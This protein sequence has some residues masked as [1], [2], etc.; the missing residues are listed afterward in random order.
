MKKILSGVITMVLLCSVLVG[1]GQAAKPSAETTAEG[2]KPSS[3]T[4]TQL[5]DFD[6]GTFECNYNGA[7]FSVP[8][9]WEE[10]PVSG[11][12]NAYY[13]A[14]TTSGQ[15]FLMVWTNSLNESV[16][17]E[18][19]M[20]ALAE[21]MR[22]GLENGEVISCQAENTDSGVSYASIVLRGEAAGAAGTFSNAMFNVEGG[23]VAF[24][25]FQQ[26]GCDRDFDDD[27]AKI[28]NSVTIS[29]APQAAESVDLQTEPE[30]NPAPEEK[31]APKEYTFTAGNYYTDEDI[32][33]GRYDVIWVSGRGT[34]FGGGMIESFGDRD[35]Y[36]KEYKNVEL[37]SGDKVKVS[38]T[39]AIKFVSK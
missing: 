8:T 25:M 1:C 37:T 29:K 15:A 24:G 14:T 34:G 28:I 5:S 30:E 36:L 39:L 16:V 21:G 38:G 12:N 27:Y 9:A 26:D 33:A 2:A 32:P 35:G 17:D 23:V 20:L 11:N 18:P 13:H 22:K 10:R 6:A 3:E 4:V 31:P 19:I 7:T